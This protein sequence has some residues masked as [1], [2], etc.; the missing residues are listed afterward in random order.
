MTLAVSNTG[1]AAEA[2]LTITNHSKK[3][4]QPRLQ[5]IQHMKLGAGHYDYMRSVVAQV[6]GE[7]I[8][9]PRS[10]IG[11]YVNSL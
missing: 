7:L 5:L 1:G 11:M 9:Q 3:P 2:T 8:V 6:N 4:V 10:S